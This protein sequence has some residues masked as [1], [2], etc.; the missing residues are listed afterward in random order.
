MDRDS[1][2]KSMIQLSTVCDA[3]TM[4]NQIILFDGHDIHFEDCELHY[5]EDITIQP[6]VLKAGNS[7]NYQPND[8]GPNEKLKSCYNDTN[9]SWMLKYGTTKLLPHQMNSILVQA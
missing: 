6:F 2:L 5:M 8:N 3:S 7:G 1:Y 4:N 9:T